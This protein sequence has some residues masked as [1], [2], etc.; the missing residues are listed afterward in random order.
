M[1]EEIEKKSVPRWQLVAVSVG[2]GIFAW[3]TGMVVLIGV[4]LAK[5]PAMEWFGVLITFV[6][7]M[8]V[9]GLVL[10]SYPRRW[11]RAALIVWIL[12]MMAGLVLSFE[13]WSMALLVCVGVYSGG[14]LTLGIYLKCVGQGSRRMGLASVV[15]VG[16]YYVGRI[17][18]FPA[19]ADDPEKSGF[20]KEM[21]IEGFY[22]YSLGGLVEFDELWRVDGRCDRVAAR[23]EEKYEV[24]LVSELPEGFF[25]MRPYYWPDEVPENGTMYASPGFSKA[26]RGAEKGPS[27]VHCVALVDREAERVYVWVK[28]IL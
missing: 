7:T 10:G 11:F 16:L 24:Q 20:S 13:D 25:Q 4:L 2:I 18:D 12:M 9:L 17:W 6:W 14:I 8:A 15:I 5:G 27:G 23:L 28:Q 22:R 19:F 3:L 1:R 21:G 26:D